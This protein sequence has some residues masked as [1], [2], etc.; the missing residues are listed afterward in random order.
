MLR[1][2][3]REV[4]PGTSQID[5][6][7]KTSV[8]QRWLRV[9]LV[10]AAVLVPCFWQHRVGGGD[11]RSHTYNAWLVQLIERGQA[12]GLWIAHMRNNV[13]FDYILSALAGILSLPQAARAAAGIAV[14]TFFWGSF[15]FVSAITARNAWPLAP[16]L[17]A[18]AYGWTFQEG[19][20][21][22]YISIG[23]AFVAL[24][25][26]LGQNVWRW[27][28]IAILV[29]LAFLAHPLGTAWMVAAAVYLAI[30]RAIPLRLHLPLVLVAMA[31]LALLRQQ[32]Q[33]H[34]V[35][36]FPTTSALFNLLFY[37]GLDQI[38]FSNRYLIPVLMLC[39]SFVAVIAVELV[40][41]KSLPGLPAE[42][43]VPLELYLI[44]QAAVLL[45]PDS[46]SLPQYPAPVSALTTRLTS[47]SAVLL[48]CLWASIKPPRWHLSVSV[49]VTAIFFLFLYQDTALL[50]GMEDRV[51]RLVHSIPAGQ[52]VIATIGGPAKF[53]FSV[54]HMTDTSC[55]GY[56]F[57][58]GNY[59]APSGQFRVHASPGNAFVVSDIH[60]AT[61]MEEGRYQ[62]RVTDLPIY[63]V[64]QC[65][66]QWTELCIRSLKTGETNDTYGVHVG[67]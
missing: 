15:A 3:K 11:L 39:V 2:L 25:L 19:L 45:L 64:Y 14:L 56:C 53:R 36:D 13:L 16:L 61:L 31:I 47:I 28:G 67:R 40:R 6:T 12:P 33:A 7:S 4:P 23:L 55:I 44:V 5:F 38:I 58:Y 24:A 17:A 35:V 32:L 46:I 60:D 65:S 41:R 62:V 22:Y 66:T 37:N 52:R 18:I 21:N 1:K 54:K 8:R 9:L 51:Q 57:S 26:F 49:C 10:S 48:C 50:N 59:E 34:Y 43:A 63:Q 27:A 29:P 20:L 42:W 30:A